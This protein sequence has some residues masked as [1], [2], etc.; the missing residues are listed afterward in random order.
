MIAVDSSVALDKSVI[1][2]VTEQLEVDA[3]AQV[4]CYIEIYPKAVIRM[5]YLSNFLN[6]V[7][8][9]WWSLRCR[10][11]RTMGAVGAEGQADG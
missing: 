10:N 1:T 6:C 2:I 11:L 3:M 7:S 9:N 4:C 8:L 5:D